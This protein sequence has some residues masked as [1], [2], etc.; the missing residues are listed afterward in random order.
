MNCFGK[1]NGENHHIPTTLKEKE[2]QQ[3]SSCDVL[4]PNLIMKADLANFYW[5]IFFLCGWEAGENP[6]I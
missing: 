5:F 3:A 6:L 2:V 1:K 4:A